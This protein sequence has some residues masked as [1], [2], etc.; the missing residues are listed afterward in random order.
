MSSPG[1]CA[2]DV[3]RSEFAQLARVSE[4]RPESDYSK[5]SGRTGRHNHPGYAYATE[6]CIMVLLRSL[7][8]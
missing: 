1:A 6:F 3:R 4:L 7:L 2:N 8:Y 5:S